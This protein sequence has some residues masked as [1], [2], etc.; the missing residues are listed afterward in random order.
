M[1][2]I[3]L[4]KIVVLLLI[5]TQVFSQWTNMQNI[6]G[7]DYSSERFGRAISIS[8]DGSVLA[9]GAYRDGESY[10]TYGT[11]DQRGS[12]RIYTKDNA[13]TWVETAEITSDDV[14]GNF[15]YSLSLSADGNTL[16]IGAPLA[17]D[18]QV[19]DTGTYQYL[20]TNETGL[21]RI[22]SKN[23][24][25][26]W[27]QVG[28]DIVGETQT[29]F[30][31]WSISISDDGNTFVAGAYGYDSET[32]VARVYNKDATDNWIKS[33]DLSGSDIGDKTGYAVSLSSDGTTVAVG[34]FQH[35][36]Y[37]GTTR[38]YN[39][40][41]SAWTQIGT[42]IDGEEDY[43]FSGF[44]ISLNGDGTSLLIGAY[45]HNSNGTARLYNYS[46]NNWTKEIQIDAEENTFERFG[47]AVSITADAK[48][49]A[50]GA[51]QSGE[52]VGTSRVYS[53]V[54]DTWSQQGDD[55]V[56]TADFEYSSSAISLADN[57]STLAVG[58]YAGNL[59]DGVVRLYEYTDDASLSTN[60]I[61]FQEISYSVQHQ[62]INVL[63]ENISLD[64]YDLLGRI[65]ENNNLNGVY[66][67]RFTDE[68]NGNKL[69]K[70]I[71]IN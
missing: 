18:G 42:D 26:T 68:T 41:I 4:F 55:M 3:I 54:D 40:N 27:I 57:G 39:Y 12:V 33:T 59:N 63:S 53:K 13:N 46:E 29:E 6:N 47:Y 36:S 61:T 17:G 10:D 49:F 1:K 56:G 44:A 32:G 65:S 50:V 28:D 9:V 19:V 11:L 45:S 23:N 5:N 69:T 51:S 43:D 71:L 8:E 22:Y 58:A 70:K 38:T 60:D 16:A 52:Y 34:A 14:G 62:K 31:G 35:D 25:G 37:K 67:V 24:A 30:F 7:I 2:K 20:S 15:G 64:I 48:T 66:V 21:V